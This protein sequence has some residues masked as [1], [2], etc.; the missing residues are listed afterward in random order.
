M[1]NRHTNREYQEIAQM[2]IDTMPELEHLRGIDANIILLS[3]EH[4]KKTRD[5]RVYGQCEKIPSKYKWSIPCEFTITLFEPNIVDFTD[6]QIRILIFHE[7]LHIGVDG[8]NYYIVHHDLE[9]FRTIIKRYG[10]DWDQIGRPKEEE[11]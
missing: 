3:S 7:L 10:T 2:L 8:D 9:D 5:R 6:E 11:H 4:E 1:D